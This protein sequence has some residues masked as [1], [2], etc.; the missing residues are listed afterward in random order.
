VMFDIEKVES[1][2]VEEVRI[3][4]DPSPTAYYYHWTGSNDI[5]IATMLQYHLM[6]DL[7]SV[8]GKLR[9]VHSYMIVE[10]SFGR[11]VLHVGH[12]EWDQPPW[13]LHLVT[14]KNAMVSCERF[15]WVDR[16]ESLLGVE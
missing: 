14:Y 13:K 4:Y 5:D 10:S 1:Y 6:L 11:F 3:F 7:L 9:I 15:S 12:K 8:G 16:F 2:V